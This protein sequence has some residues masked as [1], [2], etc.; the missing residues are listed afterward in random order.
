M[1]GE[2]TNQMPPY[3]YGYPPPQFNPYYP[4]PS[5]E[6][7]LMSRRI[8]ST[9]IDRFQSYLES[10]E[11]TRPSPKEMQTQLLAEKTRLMGDYERVIQML[12][13]IS[14]II[15]KGHTNPAKA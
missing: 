11:G 12:A 3:G 7:D 14:A 10:F 13:Q 2:Q 15:A 8:P 6:A 9:S 1:A 5:I 4:M